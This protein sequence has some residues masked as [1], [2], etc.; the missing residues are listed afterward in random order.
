M[1]AAKQQASD[2]DH[3]ERAFSDIMSPTKISEPVQEAPSPVDDNNSKQAK[4]RSLRSDNAARFSEPPAPPPQQP[5]PEKPDSAKSTMNPLSITKNFLK[6]S[7]TAKAASPAIA[8]SKN[9]HGLTN[10]QSA[11]LEA[12][13]RDLDSQRARVKQLEDL[14]Q[15]EK[16]ARVRAEERAQRFEQDFSSKPVTEIEEPPVV[17]PPP[18]SLEL[19]PQETFKDEP[20]PVDG[21]ESRLQQRLDNMVLEM[22]KMKTDMDRYQKRAETAEADASKSRESL[23]QMIERLR[24]ENEAEASSARD[25]DPATTESIK[26]SS[27]EPD[28]VAVNSLTRGQ[29]TGQ[30]AANGHIA[31]PKL[32]APLQQAVATALRHGSSGDREVLMQSAPY[33]SALGVVLIGIGMMAYLNSWQKT[34]R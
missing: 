16:H 19:S 12:V 15:E 27:A 9:E 14:L 29:K 17:L 8:Q 30:P 7:D 33:V 1:R 31:T 5:L 34:D 32:P 25:V 10:D 13:K 6:R 3:I 20:T 28:A 21:S 11:L 22:Q 2:L 24:Q 18:D 4:P 26:A 23:S